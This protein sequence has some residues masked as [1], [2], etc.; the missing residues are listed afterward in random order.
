MLDKVDIM[1]E[2]L[3]RYEQIVSIKDEYIAIIMEQY[4]HQLEIKLVIELLW[5]R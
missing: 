3:D 5:G 4:I 1:K 2:L